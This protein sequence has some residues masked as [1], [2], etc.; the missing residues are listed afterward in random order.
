[1]PL[2]IMV[3]VKVDLHASLLWNVICFSDKNFFILELQKSLFKR[4]KKAK[5]SLPWL[6]W[7]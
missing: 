5:V 7:S 1:M 4:F 2:G 3:A 6:Q